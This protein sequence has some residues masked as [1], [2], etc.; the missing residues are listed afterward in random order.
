MTRIEQILFDAM[1][2]RGLQPIPQYGI[3]RYRADF[4]FTHPRVVVECDGKPWHDPDRDP[5]TPR[6]VGGAHR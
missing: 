4:A 6:E 2:S 1:R 3:D 5:G